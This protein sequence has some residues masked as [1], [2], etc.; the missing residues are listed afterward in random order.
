MHA[1]WVLQAFGRSGC[2]LPSTLPRVAAM[3]FIPLPAHQTSLNTLASPSLL[4]RSDPHRLMQRTLGSVGLVLVLAPRLMQSQVLCHC[5]H[6]VLAVYWE[7]IKE[8]GPDN[9]V[10]IL[11]NGVHANMSFTSR[12]GQACLFL[13]CLHAQRLHHSKRCFTR[14]AMLSRANSAALCFP[15]ACYLRRPACSSMQQAARGL[16]I[17]ERHACMRVQLTLRRRRQAVNKGQRPV[18]CSAASGG[19]GMAGGTLKH[20]KLRSWFCKHH[21]QFHPL[22]HAGMKKG[23]T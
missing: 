9:L 8:A 23:S 1:W 6:Q 21:V 15:P 10:E 19:R 14:S 7:G 3:T 17:H 5:I 18:W 4:T 13:A 11:R 22:P 16:V 12:E 20:F 2:A